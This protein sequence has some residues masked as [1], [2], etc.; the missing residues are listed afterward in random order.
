MVYA[1]LALA[2]AHVF[3]S[4]RPLNNSGELQLKGVFWT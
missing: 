1:P 4:S 3:C 2:T